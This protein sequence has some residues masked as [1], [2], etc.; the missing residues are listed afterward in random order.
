[1]VTHNDKRNSPVKRQSRIIVFKIQ[2]FS[3]SQWHLIN[4]SKKHIYFLQERYS[5][6]RLFQ[7]L[8]P[9]PLWNSFSI[10]SSISS[11]LVL[12]Q[13]FYIFIVPPD[14]DNQK[15][16][17]WFLHWCWSTHLP[18][19]SN[20]GNASFFYLADFMSVYFC[21]L[22]PANARYFIIPTLYEKNNIFPWLSCVSRCYNLLC[23]YVK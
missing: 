9:D 21:I 2:R 15:H 10:S 7:T 18:A 20:S 3:H 23:N 8:M 19:H 6:I 4:K 13:Q 14:N 11:P 16:L 1:M 5:S 12:H 22:P 17:L